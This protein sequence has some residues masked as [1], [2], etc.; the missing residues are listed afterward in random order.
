VTKKLK[1]LF[2]CTGNSARSIMAEALLNRLG[3]DKFKAFSAGSNP[4]GEINPYTLAT[5]RKVGHAIDGLRSKGWDE[6]ISPD[7]PSLDFVFTLCDA[8]AA[9]ECPQWP[10]QPTTAH[11]RL[12]DPAAVEGSE[13]LK[14]LAF[15]DAFRMLGNRISIFVALPFKSLDKLSLQRRLDDIGKSLPNKESA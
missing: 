4:K 13:A 9:E 10:G 6:F 12:P 7:A 1:V 15:A 8:A 11:W 14:H 5:L 3:A 2:L